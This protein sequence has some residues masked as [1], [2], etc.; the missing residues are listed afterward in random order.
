MCIDV[1]PKKEI[2]V[3]TKVCAHPTGRH[4]QSLEC[5]N[6]CTD[7]CTGMCA[8]MTIDTCTDTCT[9]TCIDMCTGM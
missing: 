8:D 7:T 5:A 1:F 2:D 9:H 6:M 4:V 3:F